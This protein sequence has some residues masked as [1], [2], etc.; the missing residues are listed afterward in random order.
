[1]YRLG[2]GRTAPNTPHLLAV[3]LE[4]LSGNVHELYPS[5]LWRLGMKYLCMMGRYF[6]IFLLFVVLTIKTT[7]QLCTKLSEKSP[8]QRSPHAIP[9]SNRLR[10]RQ[11]YDLLAVTVT[12]RMARLA[13][14][15]FNLHG[16]ESRDR[17]FCNNLLLHCNKRRICKHQSFRMI[18]RIFFQAIET[19]HTELE[20]AC[21]CSNPGY[22]LF[23]WW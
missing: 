16:H 2:S 23:G 4:L 9:L 5:F 14:P 7:L 1:M 11:L 21:S 12:Y 22:R 20:L 13:S 18:S 6:R 15:L 19:Q 17:N 3:P 8:L 10:S